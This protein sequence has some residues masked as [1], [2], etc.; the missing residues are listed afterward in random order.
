LDV[1]E[2]LRKLGGRATSKELLE[3]LAPEKG[4]MKARL[5]IAEA[6][7]E[8]KI[9]KVPDHELKKEVFAV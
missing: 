5:E 2:A 7:R 1:V 9:K 4:V 3:L 6:V 8:G